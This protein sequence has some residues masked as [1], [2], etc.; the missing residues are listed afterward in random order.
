MFIKHL[1][2][3]SPLVT[4]EATFTGETPSLALALHTNLTLLEE[5]WWCERKKN[6]EGSSVDGSHSSSRNSS[7]I[8]VN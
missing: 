1:L 7:F 6:Y 3:A 2:C 5:A 8:T 4:D